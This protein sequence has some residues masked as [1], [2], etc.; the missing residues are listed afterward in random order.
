VRES[1]TRECEVMSTNELDVKVGIGVAVF[2][3]DPY[4]R[5]PKTLADELGKWTEYKIVDENRASWIAQNGQWL[6]SQIKINKKTLE[7][8]GGSRIMWSR[9][10]IVKEWNEGEFK[11]KHA[12]S[13]AELVKRADVDA[14]ISVA[15]IFGWE[16]EKP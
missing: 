3:H 9:D 2:V 14:L 16:L 6:H 1:E 11:S 4:G 15:K 13:L 7:A 10:A 12:N 5:T 8:R